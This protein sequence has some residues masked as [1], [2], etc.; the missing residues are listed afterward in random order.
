MQLVLQLHD[1]NFL[2]PSV[3]H[4]PSIAVKIRSGDMLYCSTDWNAGICRRKAMLLN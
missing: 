1:T 4:Q 3:A 2:L